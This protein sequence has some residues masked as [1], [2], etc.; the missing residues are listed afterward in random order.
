MTIQS[1]DLLK[2]ANNL[3]E[4][5]TA[6]EA[7]F[8]CSVSR[9]YYSAY[10]DSKKWSLLLP[11]PG[12]PPSGASGTH[13]EFCHR[14]QNPVVATKLAGKST[15]SIRRGVLLKLLHKERVRADY[16]LDETVDKLDATNA[17]AQAK[18]ISEIL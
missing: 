8:R 3:K 15:A 14:L 18:L 5:S 1:A 13:H 9:A 2:C 17:T 7:D 10:H 11:A 6:T 4:L 16:D 12:I